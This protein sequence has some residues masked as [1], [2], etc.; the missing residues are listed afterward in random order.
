[1]IDS[2]WILAR[3]LLMCVACPFAND[4]GKVVVFGWYFFVGAFHT[5]KFE[6]CEI[7]AWLVEIAG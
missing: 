6:K 7:R 1:M 3:Q 2:A 4:L 5:R